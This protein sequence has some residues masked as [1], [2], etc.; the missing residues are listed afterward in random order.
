VVFDRPAG[1][2]ALAV[3]GADV[4]LLFGPGA[5]AAAPAGPASAVGDGATSAAMTPMAAPPPAAA[6]FTP[7]ASTRRRPLAPE[8]IAAA[9]AVILL[10]VYV[11]LAGF[12]SPGAVWG[13]VKSSNAGLAAM[14]A[15]SDQSIVLR[16]PSDF[17]AGQVAAGWILVKRD[18]NP[19]EF[20]AVNILEAPAEDAPDSEKTGDPLPAFYEKA[21]PGA[22]Y[23]SLSSTAVTCHDEAGI[24]WEGTLDRS[25]DQTRVVACVFYKNGYKYIVA[26]GVPTELAYEDEP[27]LERMS[28]GVSI[29]RP[30][31]LFFMDRHT[32]FGRR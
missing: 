29:S 9:I 27:L 12:H 11:G 18:D 21:S 16:Y 6:A 30:N 3:G 22:T 31:F 13:R 20:V 5:A 32:P 23:T 8:K 19:R 17:S 26:Y 28:A 15:S 2:C 14:H 24:K 4:P 25:T 7:L 10:L 1:T